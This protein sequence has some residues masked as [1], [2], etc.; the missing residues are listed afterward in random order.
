MRAVILLSPLLIGMFV[1][2]NLDLITSLYATLR[3]EI[4]SPEEPFRG[5]GVDVENRTQ[6]FPMHT[7]QAGYSDVKWELER[8][9]RAMGIPVS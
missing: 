7:N 4:M 2:Y 5:K 9:Y 3:Y 6:A 8:R 1:L